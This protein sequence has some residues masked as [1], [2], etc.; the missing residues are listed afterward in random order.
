MDDGEPLRWDR[1]NTQRT[2]PISD[3]GLTLP[4][5]E[6]SEALWLSAQTTG[7]LPE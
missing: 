3:D 5:K 4:W 1:A 2:L 6:P 7:R